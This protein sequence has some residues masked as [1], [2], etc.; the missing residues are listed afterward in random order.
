M[1]YVVVGAGA[2]GGTVG[3]RLARDGHDVLFCDADRDHVAAI[4][5]RGL[6]DRRPGRA[7]AGGRPGRAAGGLAGRAGSRPA[8]GQGAPHGERDGGRRAAAGGGRLRGLAA[9]R[10]Q[11]AGDRR[12]G[13]GAPCGGRLRQLRRRR[14]SRPGRILL[15]N[16]G[17]FRIGELDGR[18]S[19]RV[20][21]LV[22]D[23][24]DAEATDNVLGF[25]WSKQAYG[26]MLFAT[27]VSDLSI[28]DALADAAYR[29]LF[30]RARARGAGRRAVPAGAVRRLRPRRPGGLDRPAGRVQPALG[31]D[32]LA[33]STATWRCASRTTEVDAIL[34]PGRSAAGAAHGRADPRNRGR[35]PRPASG[36]TSTCSR[37]TSGSRRWARR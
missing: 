11:R 28:A 19:D 16:R 8:G 33:A 26:A 2:I 25:L 21:A 10:P 9:E 23:I 6:I 3:A 35:P 13:R 20:D 27:A 12:G 30:T 15:G 32:P 1:E 37:P 4:N 17:T 36:R 14:T 22:G 7:A 24:E 34:R 18:P 29:P 5:E 31:E